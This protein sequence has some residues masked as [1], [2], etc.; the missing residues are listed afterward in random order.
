MLA[1]RA[2]S[3]LVILGV[4]FV[5]LTAVAAIV[6]FDVIM[7]D[8][9]RGP[10]HEYL[11]FLPMVVFSAA[12]PTMNSLYLSLARRLNVWEVR[13]RCISPAAF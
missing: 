8:L 9:Y 2:T 6:L 5:V 11:R 1:R 7:A 3:I 13:T 4:S 10:F 12:I